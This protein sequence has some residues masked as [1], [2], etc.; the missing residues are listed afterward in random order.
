MIAFRQPLL[1]L[2]ILLITSF[3]GSTSS[4][5]RN[6][7]GEE[8]NSVK[9]SSWVSSFSHQISEA[10][11]KASSSAGWFDW[12]GIYFSREV[13][14][15]PDGASL[16]IEV[17]DSSKYCKSHDENG[18]DKCTFPWD[19]SVVITLHSSLGVDLDSDDMLTG[20]LTVDKFAHLNFECNICG[21]PCTITIPKVNY[22]LSLT[23]PPCPI[24]GDNFVYK[25]DK[26]LPT[27]GLLPPVYTDGVFK[28][29]KKDGTQVAEAKVV[30]D[31]EK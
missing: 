26:T 7:N 31:V 3:H 9:K 28:I 14:N 20:K 27:P 24:K 5:L 25:I 10:K 22:D 19:K 13:T 23:V 18:D 12:H 8:K 6:N 16:S 17:T 30:V 4:N 2:S 15:L 29:V 1:L 21:D 11:E